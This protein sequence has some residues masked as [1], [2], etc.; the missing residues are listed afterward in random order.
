MDHQ[1]PTPPSASVTTP[2]TLQA[3]EN[4]SQPPPQ[5][6]QPQPQSQPPPTSSITTSST[7]VPLLPPPNPNPVG[8]QNPNPSPNPIPT[9]TPNP[10]PKP[11]TPLPSLQ[12]PQQHPQSV[13]TPVQTRPPAA[14]P[15][16]P[17]QQ[18]HFSHFS[19]APS[20]SS[21]SLSTGPPSS[22]SPSPSTAAPPPPRG[23]I[24]LGVPAHH[25]SPS[26]PQPAPFSSSYGQHF[27]GLGRGGVNLPE[28]SSTSNALQVKPPMQG[29][30][31][32][33]MLGSINSSSQMRPVGIPA[34]N[35][36]RPVQSSLRPQSNSNT[37][38]PPQ[39]FQG[40]GLLRASSV[41]SPGSSS[42]STSQNMQSLN[43]PWLSSGSQGKP[44]LPSPSYRQQVNSQSLQQRSHLPQ[45]HSLPGASQQQHMTASQQQQPSTANQTHEHFG[46]QVSS[47]RVPQA[48][49]HQ[50]HITR[51]Q[52][53]ITPKSSSLATVQPGTA[54]SGSQNRTAAKEVDETSNRILSKRSIHELVNQ[55]DPSER[56]DPEV[57]D[58]LM[59][60]ADDFVESITTF[61]CSLA[62]HRKSTMLEA[63]DIL[64]HLDR[65]WNINLPGFGGDEI[66]T[67]RKPI[68]N[69][70]HKERLAAI[71]KSM[72]VTETANTRNSTGQATG[73][74]KGSIAKNPANVL[75]SPNVKS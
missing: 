38:P 10:N 37:Q 60:I 57:E 41:G 15:R 52:G 42:P 56:L 26:P 27:G 12:S 72:A 31:G 70:I 74:A 5:P 63:K 54:Q 19:S 33:G 17:W 55:I 43:Q 25:P 1:N 35:Q 59:D 13:T 64:L 67:Y 49:S 71:K 8:N 58:I 48:L 16:A 14:L 65:N 2:T 68:M 66:K 6:P 20:S 51:V 69:D 34:H 11:T 46:Q 39:N 47:S 50:Q 75:G 4:P 22:S 24:A 3:S 9:Q 36:Q 62:K 30:Q 73:N 18:S 45:Q 28:P 7:P 40:H 21:S 53:S 61:G 32:M 44:P 23:G 29:M